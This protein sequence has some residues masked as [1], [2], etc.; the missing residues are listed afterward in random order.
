[1]THLEGT[2]KCIWMLITFLGKTMN[3]IKITSFT[4]SIVL[5]MIAVSIMV[6]IPE[7]NRVSRAIY[8]FSLVILLF[9]DIDIRIKF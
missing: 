8:G 7:A 6:F 5:I 9:T 1:M 3:E 4:I 2:H